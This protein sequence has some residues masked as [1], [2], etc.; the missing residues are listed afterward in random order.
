[1]MVDLETK[2]RETYNLQKK[3]RHEHMAHGRWRGNKRLQNGCHFNFNFGVPLNSSINH[4]ENDSVF[5]V[6]IEG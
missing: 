5:A 3:R 6:T 2:P 4:R 1:M